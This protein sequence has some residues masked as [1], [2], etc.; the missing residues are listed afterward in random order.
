MYKKIQTSSSSGIKSPT[1][2]GKKWTK[3]IICL[4]DI[5]K[6]NLN[7]LCFSIGGDKFFVPNHH[8]K[9]SVLWSSKFQE[10]I[11]LLCL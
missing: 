10:K 6:W 8:N 2:N 4:A 7:K 5:F 1:N 9:N 3:H 11:F